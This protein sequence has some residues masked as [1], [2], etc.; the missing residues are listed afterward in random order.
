MREP[1]LGVTDLNVAFGRGP[2][3]VDDVSFDIA[4]GEIVA[5]VGESGSGKS[6]IGHALQGLLPAESR[7]IVTGSVTI[8]GVQIVGASTATLRNARRSLV[9]AV[10]QDPMAAL[11]PTMII[12]RQMAESSGDAPITEWLLRA[13]LADAE[14]IADSY[15]HR[16]SGGQR[17]RVL[18]AMAMMAAPKL[19]VADEP[20][21]ALDVTIQAQILDMLR[22]LAQEHR[23]AV[24][25][26]THDL[27]VA[28]SMAG[29]VLVMH[30]GKII[31]SGATEAVVRAPSHVYTRSLIASRFDLASDRTRPLGGPSPSWAE[32]W[33]EHRVKAE[34]VVLRLRRVGKSFATGLRTPLGTRRLVPALRSIDLEIRAGE[35]VALVGES[36]AGKSTLLRIA[37]GLVRPDSGTVTVG[38]NGPPQ[39]VFQDAGSSLTPWLSI[40]EQIAER[41]RSLGL[42]RREREDR[43]RE[44][45]ALVGLIPE[46]AHALPNELSGG[47][48]QRAVIAR[49]IV[50][51]PK[52]L[53]CDEPIS[54]L[55]VS[56]GAA[57]LNLLGTLRRRLGMAMLFVTHDLAAAR[58]IADRIV[59]L[60]EGELIEEADPD[61]L[62]VASRMPYTRQLIASVPRLELAP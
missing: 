10:P 50:V 57:T 1:I 23:T 6:T 40:G 30:E 45:M 9:R 42:P 44:T 7:P 4:S 61:T 47:Q 20:A 56:L 18:I 5:L 48:A 37:A 60:N 25:L 32:L 3:V 53:L 28:A 62:I 39:I 19:L 11:D 33:P 12:R 54:A 36:G 55:D 15:P 24:L 13:G 16:L 27:A 43:L 38:D 35:S 34:D 46:L 14:R 26:I 2:R 51:V 29:R 31:E 17:Q 22:A 52:L 8:D 59:V 21:T 41:L 58:I 49:A